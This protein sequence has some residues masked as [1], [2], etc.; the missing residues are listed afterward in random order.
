MK[1]ILFLIILLIMVG[2][3]DDPS[4]D[5]S[6]PKWLAV[7]IQE[8]E[9]LYAKDVSMIKI[10]IYKCEWKGS[11]VYHIFNLWESCGFC[12]NTFYQDGKIIEWDSGDE[13]SD[14]CKTSEN[15]Q[16]IYEFGNGE[17]SFN[18]LNWAY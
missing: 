3:D 10:G 17:L 16:L 4:E 18:V 13:V 11:T 14:F 5:N 15:W 2:C 9:T 8:I 7:K 6:Y 1:N 12:D